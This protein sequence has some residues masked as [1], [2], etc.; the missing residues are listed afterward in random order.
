MR[1][2]PLPYR[3]IKKKL[4]KLGF[5]II[6]QKGSHVFFKHS[7]GRTTIVPRHPGEDIGKGL[8]RKIL[9]DIDISVE[10]FYKEI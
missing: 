2:Y 4:E 1:I 7:N 6:R 10:D 8:L 9:R 5:Q 3:K